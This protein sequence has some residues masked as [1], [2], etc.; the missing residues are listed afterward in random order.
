MWTA[1]RAMERECY[2]EKDRIR[3]YLSRNRNWKD[4][5]Q[6]RVFD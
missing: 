5:Q 4:P 1:Q 6:E 3:Q 2:K